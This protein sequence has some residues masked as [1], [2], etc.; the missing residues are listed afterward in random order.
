MTARSGSTPNALTAQSPYAV[1]DL[2]DA[3]LARCLLQSFVGGCAVHEMLYDEDGRPVDY[4]FLAANEIYCEMSH[5]RP[6][7]LLGRTVREVM[8]RMELRWLERY[9]E[10]VRSG[11]TL[12]FE[13]RVPEFDKILSLAVAKAGERRF[14]LSFADVSERESASEALTASEAKIA[15]VFRAAPF[16][17]GWTRDRVIQDVNELVCRISG[18]E[19]DELVGR[20]ARLFYPN[21]AEFERVGRDKYLDIAR[22]GTGTVEATW[23]RKDGTDIDVLLSSTPLVE[24]DTTQGVTF[25]VMDITAEKRGARER[26][27]LERQ[28]VQAQKLEA[29]G[30]L[31]AGISHDFNNILSAVTGFAELAQGDLPPDSAAAED[32]AEVLGAAERARE[33]VGRILAFSRREDEPRSAI[34]LAPVVQEAATLLRRSIPT[35]VVFDVQVA[36]EC[37]AVIAEETRIHQVVVNLVMNAYHAVQDREDRGD[38]GHVALTFDEVRLPSPRYRRAL[39]LPPGIYARLSVRDNGSGMDEA[40]TLRIFDPYFTTKKQ[41]QG[42]GLGL[43]I[44]HGIVHGFGGGVYVDSTPDVGSEFVVLLPCAGRATAS[45]KG[46]DGEAELLGAERVLL[47]DDD[48]SVLRMAVRALTRYGYDVSSAGDGVAALQAFEA[49]PDRFDIVITDQAMPHMTGSELSAALLALRP[50]LPI[51]LC[52]GFSGAVTA[53]KA[54]EL[55]IREFVRKPVVGRELAA[56][57]RHVLD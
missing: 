21:E 34:A 5:K 22:F 4:R 7:E 14:V 9:E 32:I 27:E 19:R 24:G 6:D 55:G 15:S 40:T 54:R 33:L 28:L 25:T 49:D 17:V 26:E 13:A 10:V 31:A 36:R 53:D 1:E 39:D 20:S 51:V 47:V 16:G 45:E 11:R 52:T 3:E 56:V 8:P 50:G 37:Q 29:I 43:A 44:V 41:G 2:L 48:V 35:S 23:R 18:Y 57:I 30:T 42:T 12:R 38:Q 46:S